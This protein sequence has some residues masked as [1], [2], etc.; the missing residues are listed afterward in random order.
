MK[1]FGM[2]GA[3]LPGVWVGGRCTDQMLKGLVHHA[4]KSELHPVSNREPLRYFRHGV[5]HELI[6]SLGGPIYVWG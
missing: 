3:Q 5:C 4:T 2:A 1:Q 6:Y